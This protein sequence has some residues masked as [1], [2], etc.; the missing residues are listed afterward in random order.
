MKKS[1]KGNDGEQK[2][3]KQSEARGEKTGLSRN[4]C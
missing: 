1:K 3:G 2:K 4:I